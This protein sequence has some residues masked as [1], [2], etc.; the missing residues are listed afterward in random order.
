MAFILLFI[1]LGV[2]TSDQLANVFKY[3]IE[4]L[5][6]CHEPSLEGLIREVKCGGSFGFYSAHASNTFFLSTFLTLLLGKTYRLLPWALFLWAGTVAY[7]RIYLGVHYPLDVLYGAS[8][9]FLLGGFY[10]ALTRKVLSK[11]AAAV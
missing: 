4:R 11:R 5:R 2:T 9:G 3:G 8:V 6:P 7:S 1:A 10:G